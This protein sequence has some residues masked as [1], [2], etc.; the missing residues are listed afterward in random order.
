MRRTL[1]ITIAVLAAVLLVAVAVT[2]RPTARRVTVEEDDEA[3]PLHVFHSEDASRE[4]RVDCGASAPADRIGHLPDRP[5]FPCRFEHG[6]TRPTPWGRWS[7]ATRSSL[8]VKLADPAPRR[9]LLEC[10]AQPRPDSPAPQTMKVEFNGRPVGSFEVPTELR[11]ISV[12]LP[13][14]VQRRGDNR[15]SFEFGY[16]AEEAPSDRG[17]HQRM[18]SVAFRRLMLER[19]RLSIG[20]RARRPARPARSQV[21]DAGRERFVLAGAGRL[22]LPLALPEAVS[23][24]EL[25]VHLPP[26]LKRDDTRLLL[27]LSDVAG[28]TSRT[29]RLPVEDPRL[30][31]TDLVLGQI[32][33]ADLAGSTCL[34]ELAV[35]PRPPSEVIEVGLP[36]MIPSSDA[37]PSP[38]APAEPAV[39][40]AGERMP[41]IVL[42]TLDAARADHFGCYGYHLP[43]TPNIDRFAA[44][45]LVFRN[46]Y[47]LAPYTL[48]SVATMITGTRTASSTPG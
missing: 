39:E 46:A 30:E 3:G 19:T 45:S 32:P 15:V 28:T 23:T 42:I 48:N 13:A 18:L 29:V 17:R 6:W 7:N 26:R 14:E 40:R 36:R 20:E 4:L 8:T 31:T 47:A 44:D 27:T 41:D 5:L 11:Q 12:P 34:L 16:I 22:T 21:W 43:T 9:L 38:A 33:V 1:A 24:L 25:D 37:A 10:R 2:L 35:A